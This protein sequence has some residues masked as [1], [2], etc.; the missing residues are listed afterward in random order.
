[1]KGRKIA[2]PIE[3]EPAIKV[4]RVI[5][6]ILNNGE[7][8]ENL[9]DLSDVSAL[10]SLRLTLNALSLVAAP[11]SK[12]DPYR[13]GSL[14]NEGVKPPLPPG[15]HESDAKGVTES[16]DASSGKE[17]VA[18]SFHE[19]GKEVLEFFGN[20]SGGGGLGG[21]AE[22]GG[23]TGNEIAGAAAEEGKR[24]AV[25]Y[26]PINVGSGVGYGTRGG[27]AIGLN[28]TLGKRVQTAA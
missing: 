12:V 23:M 6:K 24:R 7:G 10:E 26:V 14:R 28:S 21:G 8:E 13:V 11:G 16:T 2:L 15:F 18:P 3:P 25:P 17:V 20:G 1:M 19:S 9:G 27:D 4:D 22:S 5:G